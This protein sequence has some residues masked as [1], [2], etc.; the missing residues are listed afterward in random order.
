MGLT[1]V[2]GLLTGPTGN[3]ARVNFL[4]DS[5]ITYTLVPAEN[6]RVL[7]LQPKRSVTL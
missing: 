4:V 3:Q 7:R 2:E 6:V 1:Y 5:G